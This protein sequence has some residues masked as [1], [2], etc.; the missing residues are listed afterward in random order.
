M[1]RHFVRSVGSNLE[2]S[3]VASDALIRAIASHERT[4]EVISWLLLCLN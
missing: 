3:S 4:E 2:T 1:L